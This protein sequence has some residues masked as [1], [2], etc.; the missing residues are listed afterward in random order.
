MAS[1]LAYLSVREHHIVNFPKGQKWQVVK[2]ATLYHLSTLPKIS[3]SGTR[4]GV[5]DTY[6]LKCRTKR[7]IRNPAQRT[8][9]NGLPVTQGICSV[10]GARVSRLGWEKN[11]GS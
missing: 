4:G 1:Y 9:R 10:C 3:S 6:C 11:K 8:L 5:M 7:D 2:L